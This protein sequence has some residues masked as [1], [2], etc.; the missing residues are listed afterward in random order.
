[1]HKGS[2]HLLHVSCCCLIGP[3]GKV[4]ANLVFARF[5]TRLTQ[6]DQDFFFLYFYKVL[7]D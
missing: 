7:R 3:E 2:F 5:T 6:K 4:K 1:M